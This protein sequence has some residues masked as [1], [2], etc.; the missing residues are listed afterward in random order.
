[1]GKEP[2][3]AGSG[4][5]GE[6][7]TIRPPGDCRSHFGGG[8]H[9]QL[10]DSLARPQTWCSFIHRTTCASLFFA[11]RTWLRP[12]RGAACLGTPGLGG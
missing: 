9:R 10:T 2:V 3:P 8:G 11:S 7:Y 1:M 5:A 4:W 12:N 6:M